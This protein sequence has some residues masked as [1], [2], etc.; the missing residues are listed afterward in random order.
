MTAREIPTPSP[1]LKPVLTP[2][3]EAAATGVEEAVRVIVEWSEV[4]GLKELVKLVPA[5]IVLAPVL[6]EE[7]LVEAI[8]LGAEPDISLEVRLKARLV[9]AGAVWPLI[10]I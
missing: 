2:L 3:D 5:L 6:E 10:N 9:A 1:I 4:V 8:L 7:V